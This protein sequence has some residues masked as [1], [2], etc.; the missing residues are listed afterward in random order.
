MFFVKGNSSH[1]DLIKIRTTAQEEEVLSCHAKVPIQTMSEAAMC[2]RSEQKFPL[3]P[4]SNLGGTI[5][6]ETKPSGKELNTPS[7]YVMVPILIRF[8]NSCYLAG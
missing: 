6:F 8:P 7:P 3:V 1:K 5:L 2:P 4:A